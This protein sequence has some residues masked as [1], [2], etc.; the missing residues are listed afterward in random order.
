MCIS[1]VSWDDPSLHIRSFYCYFLKTIWMHAFYSHPSAHASRS[2]FCTVCLVYWTSSSGLNVLDVAVCRRAEWTA[3]QTCRLAAA[4]RRG[5]GVWRLILHRGQARLWWFRQTVAVT[6][7]RETK[8]GVGWGFS[9]GEASFL[10][11]CLSTDDYCRLG[12]ANRYI[13]AVK[14][15]PRHDNGILREQP[16][17]WCWHMKTRTRPLQWLLSNKCSWSAGVGFWTYSSFAVKA[18]QTKRFPVLPLKKP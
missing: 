17:L 8:K 4:P 10:P 1:V 2:D 15:P 16:A 11:L 13:K 5:Q 18:K 6:A 12:V 9:D 14:G 3:C 7:C